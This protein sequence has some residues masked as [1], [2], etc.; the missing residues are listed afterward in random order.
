MYFGAVYAVSKNLWVPI[1]PHLIINLCVFRLL[2]RVIYPTIALIACLVSYVLLVV[3]GIYILESITVGIMLD[4]FA[5][6]LAF[7]RIAPFL[8]WLFVVRMLHKVT[9]DFPSTRY[10]KSI[11]MRTSNER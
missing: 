6:E 11:C 10:N 2:Q 3:Y 5:C 9:I 7:E 8:K 1:I 4:N